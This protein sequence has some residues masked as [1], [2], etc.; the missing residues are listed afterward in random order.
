MVNI[1]VDVHFAGHDRGERVQFP[2]ND[3]DQIFGANV[4]GGGVVMIIIRF[5]FQI[6]VCVSDIKSAAAVFVCKIDLN[7]KTFRQLRYIRFAYL[8]LIS[9]NF[10]IKVIVSPPFDCV[11][12]YF[13]CLLYPEAARKST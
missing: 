7:R 10:S 6:A 3:V 13:L 5:N 2:G 12:I 9:S 1:S 11:Y 8:F 4:Y